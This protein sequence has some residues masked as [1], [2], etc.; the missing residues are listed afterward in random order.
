MLRSASASVSNPYLSISSAVMIVTEAGTSRT[1]CSYL[2]A[3][4]MRAFKR[5]SSGVAA[6]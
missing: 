6:S 4:L 2:A 5:S 1:G 3:A